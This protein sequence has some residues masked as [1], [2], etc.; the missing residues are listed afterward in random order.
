M[1]P[2]TLREAGW[3]D[4]L[5]VKAHHPDVPTTISTSNHSLFDFVL[6]CDCIDAFV[7]SPQINRIVTWAPHW[8]LDVTVPLRPLTV[9]GVVLCLPKTLPMTDFKKNGNNYW[10]SNKMSNTI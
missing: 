10:N 3:L 8:A 5:R 9:K 6:V 4:R 7:F 2:E 1:N